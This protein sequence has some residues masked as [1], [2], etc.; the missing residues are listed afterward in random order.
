MASRREP[1]RSVAAVGAQCRDFEAEG[2]DIIFLEASEN[3]AEMTR[4]C[5]AMQKPCMANMVP[6]AKTPVQHWM[7]RTR[8]VANSILQ[9]VIQPTPITKPPLAGLSR[10][11]C[12]GRF[13]SPWCVVLGI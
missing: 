5:E 11:T 8:L 12:P 9:R 13:P 4:F 7:R 6:G 2:A 10:N 1:K 3:E